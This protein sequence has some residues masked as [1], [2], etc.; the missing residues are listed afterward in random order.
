MPAFRR[1]IH[2]LSER[3]K[4]LI[5]LV[6]V[7]VVAV[8]GY[9]LYR[10][11]EALLAFPWTLRPGWLALSAAGYALDLFL[12]FLVWHRMIQFFT[13]RALWRLNARVYFVSAAA[14]RIPTP[15]WYLGSR[16]TLYPAEQVPGAAVLACS[17]LEIAFLMLAGGVYYLLFLPF[18]G[19]TSQPGWLAAGAAGLAFL[20]FNLMRPNLL[21]GWINRVL[22]WLKR[23]P[24]Q[25]SL[26]SRNLLEWFAL[27]MAVWFLNGCAFYALVRGCMTIPASFADLTGVATLYLLIAYVSMFLTAGFGLKEL[28]TGLLLTAWMPFTAGVALT[29]V[30]R[31]LMASVELLAVA[32]GRFAA[33]N[34]PLYPPRS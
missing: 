4:L 34:E 25:V 19:F 28:V 20:A 17:V 31:V 26:R 32:G 15:V 30:Y 10:E 2:F 27:Y 18:Y 1:F 33:R 23:P 9:S 12:L 24:V 8:I 6:A 3:R 13:G 11:R 29:L 5:P 22:G 14:R 21:I 7:L 16:F